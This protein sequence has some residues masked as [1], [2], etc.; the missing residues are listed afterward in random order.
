MD[1]I[2]Q[3]Y[4]V[5]ELARHWSCSRKLVYKLL[6]KGELKAFRIGDVFRISAAEVE[7]IES[8]PATPKV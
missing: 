5:S 6:E 3:A 4:S 2:K 7:R 8:N 1:A